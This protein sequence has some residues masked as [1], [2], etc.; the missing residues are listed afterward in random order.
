MRKIE[1]LPPL[2]RSA[3]HQKCCLLLGTFFRL[4]CKNLLKIKL[5]CHFGKKSAVLQILATLIAKWKTIFPRRL[6]IAPCQL[7]ITCSK[8]TIETLEK[9]VKYV[10]IQNTRTTSF[11]CFYCSLRT[12]VTSCSSVSTIDFEQLD[13][14]WEGLQFLGCLKLNPLLPGVY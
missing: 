9:E 6:L 5:C 7:T 11:W 10:Q 3:L 13:V 2:K 12:Y 14:S 8:S 1:L 4:M